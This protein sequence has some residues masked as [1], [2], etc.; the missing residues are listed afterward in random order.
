MTKKE[1]IATKKFIM[2]LERKVSECSNSTDRMYIRDKIVVLIVDILNYE[3]PSGI[4]GN[5]ILDIFLK[6]TNIITVNQSMVF[7][8]SN[9]KH[10]LLKV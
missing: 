9:R 6:N 5:F 1:Y 3:Y 10:I 8:C 7:V 4:R 2:V